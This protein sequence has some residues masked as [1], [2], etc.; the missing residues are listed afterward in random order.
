[1]IDRTWKTQLERDGFVHITDV[2]PSDIVEI[3][4]RLA[5]GSVNDY[6]E[7]EDLVRTPEGVPLKLAYALDKYPEF[8][9]ALGR[10]EISDIVDQLLPAKDSVLTWEDLLIKMPLVG[11]EVGA[12]QDIGL[13]PARQ[14]I[15]SLGISL[16]D[17]SEN[18]VYFLPGSHHLGPVTT[19]TVAAILRDCKDQ[20]VP[21][22]THAG[23]V[24][25]H[26]VHVL[27]Y[28][29]PNSSERPR[30][31]WYL[32]FRS[33]AALLERGPWNPDWAFHRRAIWVHARRAAGDQI[34]EGETNE[35][36]EYL[37]RLTRG[38]ASLRV[39]HV[40]EDT[41]YDHASPYF[42][43]SRWTDDWKTSKVAPQGTHHV[44]GENGQPL[45]AARFHEV[46]KFHEPGLAP[47]IDDSGAY[48]VTPDGRSAYESR[49]RRTFGSYEG[50]AAVDAED[51]WFHILADGTPLYKERYS[52][53]GNFQN[54]HCPVRVGQGQYFHITGDGSPA[55]PQRYRYVGD[56]RDG[57][58]V[59]QR[60]DGKHTH[61][62]TRGNLLHNRWFLDLD[63]YHK[64]HARAR[65][66][67][68][69]LHVNLNGEAIYSRRFTSVEPF[70]NGQARVEWQD[71]SLSVI[72]ESGVTILGLRA[73]LR[74]SLEELSG[75]M[76]GHWRTQVIRAAVEV[77]V[78]E[79][80]P[81]SGEELNRKCG[82]AS[83]MGGR[84]LRA[85]Q[86]LGLVNPD[87]QG[88]YRATERG[89]LLLREHSSSMADAA[90]HWGRD[91]YDAWNHLIEVSRD[92][93]PGKRGG[94]G[95]S[96]FDQLTNDGAALE[97]YHS[98]MA[99]YARH[100]YEKLASAID[101]EFCGSIL[102]AGGGTG[103]LSFALLRA[104]PRLT[105]TVMD[106]PEVIGIAV[107]PED[108]EGRCEFIAGDLFNEWPVKS[109]TVVLARVLHDWNDGDAFRILKQA[110]RAMPSGGCLYILEM[111]LDDGAPSGG[112][113]D[114]NMLVMTGGQERN[115]QQFTALLNR[116]GFQLLDVT[117]TDTVSSVIRALAE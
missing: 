28:S 8:M 81:A 30:A 58:A 98:A 89:E 101:L 68:G 49:F 17:D 54:G 4:A 93:T 103:E 32:E 1:M 69:W 9:A 115:E 11:E 80:L 64:G 108:V 23:D 37:S 16:H 67:Q 91:S 35:V 44:N 92:G 75:D 78:F 22:T 47:V 96:Y 85:L 104:H 73:P 88:S 48:H 112:L 95:T 50:R 18:P 52:W 113:L 94:Q 86:E 117:K 72:D 110:H 83:S 31:T 90:V 21:V 59:V 5:L 27:H 7:S 43:F 57:I 39:P 71:G 114:L 14:T 33:L 70:Y 25:I 61:I 102:D 74:S 76:V 97:S 20:F 45:Y 10:S 60:D 26:N 24:V 46:L 62:D 87:G 99:S 29:E 53:C 34:G 116:A 13:Y 38:Q 3:L 105:A 40:T 15:H 42:H 65:D 77:G 84:L 63:V 79:A 36:V 6:S 109:E 19:D 107:P 111:V 2:L 82:L 106:R 56:F 66:E 55:Y 51:G 41:H 12:H 100:D